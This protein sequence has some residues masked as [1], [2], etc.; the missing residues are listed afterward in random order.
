[1]NS[2]R[3]RPREASGAGSTP[4]K[5]RQVFLK[6]SL[7]ALM[8]LVLS[9]L[10]DAV[11]SRMRLFGGTTDL[12]PCAIFLI[13]VMEGAEEGCVFSLLASLFFYFSGSAPGAYVIVYISFLALGM[14]VFRQSYLRR[15]F[16]AAMLCLLTAMT[17]YEFLVFFTG[18]FLGQTVPARWS[19]FLVT[20]LLSMAAAPAL[21]PIIRSI[22]KIGGETWKD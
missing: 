17:A 1:M 20:A 4:Q 5:Q 2:G 12:L 15:G 16:S 11:L 14:A 19:V 10:Q 6:W 8:L 22:G 9:V 3:T 7:Y 18:L 13:C 21:Y